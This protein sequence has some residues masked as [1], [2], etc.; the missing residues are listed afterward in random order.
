ME[1][2]EN[3]RSHCNREHG[4]A[5][6]EQQYVMDLSGT[7]AGHVYSTETWVERVTC[8]VPSCCCLWWY[9]FDPFSATVEDKWDQNSL[10]ALSL[11]CLF[12]LVSR[13]SN[14][15]APAL[16]GLLWVLV[17]SFGNLVQKLDTGSFSFSGWPSKNF[18]KWSWLL[19]LWCILPV[20]PPWSL[21]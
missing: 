7:A 5:S 14:S 1:M 8:P 6:L 19:E 12:W 18:W 15:I 2:Q 13:G 3:S 10:A 17:I 21:N 11:C 9:F 16:T 20:F 4:V